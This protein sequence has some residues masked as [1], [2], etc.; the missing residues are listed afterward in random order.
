MKDLHKYSHLPLDI[1]QKLARLAAFT[2]FNPRPIIEVDLKGTILEVN[3]SAN[4]LFPDLE[5]KGLKHPYLADF[6]DIVK[7]IK[8]SKEPLT[9]ELKVKGRWF[10]HVFYYI[11][12]FELVHIYG[13]DITDRKE[14][15]DHLRMSEKRYHML[16]D[17]M[18]YGYALQDIIFDKNGKPA[19][20]RFI[21]VN[22][23]FEKLTKSPK[24]LIIGKT[25]NQMAQTPQTKEQQENRK[26]YDRVA[27]IGKPLFMESYNEELRKYFKLYA[28]RP[29]PGQMSFIFSDITKEKKED[30]EKNNF[31]SIMSHEL[32]NPL[33]PILANAQFIS[34][35]IKDKDHKDLALEESIATIEKQ[36]KIMANLLNDILD[37]SRLH[38]RKI[39]LRK[40]VINVCEAIKNSVKSSM[41][42][43]NTKNQNITVRFETN[44]LYIKADP[45]RF[46]QIMT[47]LIN[48]ASKYTDYKGN[49]M[50]SCK[51]KNDKVII[52]IKDDGVGMEKKKIAKIFELFTTDGESFMGIGGLGIGL[53]IVKNLVRMHNAQVEVHSEGKNKGSEFTLTFQAEQ[54]TNEGA[55]VGA[56]RQK[57]AFQPRVLVVDDNADIKNAITRLLEHKGITVS[58]AGNGKDAIK[59]SKKFN[60]DVALVDIG[61]PDINGYKV[62]K[63]L[64]KDNGKNIKLIAFTGYGQEKDKQYA[65]EAGFDHHITKPVDINQ[66][67]TLIEKP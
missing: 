44:P 13:V 43:I 2:E 6:K 67:M 38:R 7:V 8:K 52:N 21:D 60:P 23:A 25:A 3:S 53:N 46:D 57:T 45:T 37:I 62:A 39:I 27:I 24:E 50:V 59:I 55:I 15:E 40:R 48:N 31:I 28:Y 4:A 22:P 19:D 35:I 11:P 14:A 10:R 56:P 41:P 32:R 9:R 17:K 33:T 5:K 20:Y 36:A 26:K 58:S 49:I 51:I 54:P 34:T 1:Q 65:Q 29:N 47:N 12:D 42:L 30:E 63:A 66:L 64:R 16:F 61:L 18:N